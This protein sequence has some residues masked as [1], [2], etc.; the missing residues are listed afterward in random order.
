MASHILEPRVCRRVS[1]STHSRHSL[2]D[3]SRRRSASGAT[4]D[5]PRQFSLAIYRAWHASASSPSRRTILRAKPSASSRVEA[6]SAMLSASNLD[7][8]SRASL[9]GRAAPALR[10]PNES[11]DALLCR[12]GLLDR[13]LRSTHRRC[14]RATTASRARITSSCGMGTSA[15]PRDMCYKSKGKGYKRTRREPERTRRESEALR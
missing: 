15:M 2:S 14:T 8:L 7:T 9:S 6:N 5:K 10:I 4:L 3:S 1:S 12:D 13:S 11:H